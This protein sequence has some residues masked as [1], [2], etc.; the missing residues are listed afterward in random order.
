VTSPFAVTLSGA[1]AASLQAPVLFVALSSASSLPA[2]LASLD[3]VAGGS[4]GV[5]I[6][7]RDFRGARDEILFLSG[8]SSGPR[9]IA[10]IGLGSSPA[11]VH[12]L[13]RAAALAARTASK[14]G[15]GSLAFAGEQFAPAEVEAIAVGLRA[16]AWPLHRILRRHSLPAT[17]LAPVLR[18]R[19]RSE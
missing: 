2:A 11:T 4:I 3:A 9:R 5:A 8:V 15:T 1:D 18:S 19:E 14:L 6:S 13:R 10:L 16:G 7:Q 12:A 17:R